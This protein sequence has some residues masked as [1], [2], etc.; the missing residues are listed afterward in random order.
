MIEALEDF[1]G[2]LRGFVAEYTREASFIRCSRLD[3][4]F[5]TTNKGFEG[6]AHVRRGGRDNLYALCEGNIGRAA[7]RGGGRVDVFVRARDGAWETSHRVRLPQQAEFK[8][9]SALAYR[10]GQVAVASQASRRVWVARIDENARAVV[11]GSD[12]VYRFPNKS[13]GNVEGIAW[14]SSETLVAV[15]DRK[16]RISTPA[17]PKKTSPSTYSGFRRTE[18]VDAPGLAM[19]CGDL[20]QAGLRCGE[21]MALEWTDVDMVKRELTV[22]RSD[23]KGHVTAP[24]GGG[25]TT[26]FRFLRKSGEPN[27]RQLEPDRPRAQAA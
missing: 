9:Y 15:S 7:K 26:R 17:V 21:I 6:L 3:T 1:D 22:A 18:D 25:K 2:V 13:Y 20:R 11:A 27:V 24:K 5:Q 12:K 19:L 4:R 23:W 14:L 8:D 16:K 10:D